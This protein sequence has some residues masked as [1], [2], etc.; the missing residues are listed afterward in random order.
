MIGETGA[1]MG[2]VANQSL[3]MSTLERAAEMLGDITPLVMD[4]YYA[5]HPDARERF[6]YHD[7]GGRTALAGQM[8]TQVLYSLMTWF[9]PGGEIEIMLTTTIP[10]HIETL[11]VPPELFIGMLDAVCTVVRDTIP[12]EASSERTAWEDLHKLVVAF[13]NR[14]VEGINTFSLSSRSGSGPVN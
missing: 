3:V 14:E 2:N 10:H 8:V 4:K 13:S 7:P 5:S 12:Q 1:E 11:E 9:E 6:E